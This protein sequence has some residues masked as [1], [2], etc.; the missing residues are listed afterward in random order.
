VKKNKIIFLIGFILSVPSI[1]IANSNLM[2]ANES[3]QGILKGQVL[4]NTSGDALEAA[5]VFVQGTNKGA[6]TDKDGYFIISNIPQGT[7]TIIFSFIG[8]TEKSLQNIEIVSNDIVN[9]GV[10]RLKEDPIAL[11]EIIVT[12]GSF[13]IMG[14]SPVS[15]QT[16]SNEDMKNVSFAEDITRA[17]S[18]LPGISSNDFSSKFTVRGGE[19]DEVLFTLDGMELYEPFHQRDY[20]GGLFSIVDIETI[21][22]V[23]LLTGG[24]PAEYGDRQSGV[25][26]MKTKNIPDGQRQ[27][28]IGVSILNARFYTDG[29]FAENRG[30]YQ[31]SARRGMLD[32]AL[33]LVDETENIPTFYDMMGKVEYKINSNHSLSVHALQASDQTKV[34][35]ISEEAHDIHDTKYNNSYAWITLK[36]FLTPEL[37]A[38][39]LLYSGFISHSRNGDTDKPTELSDKLFFQL[40]DKRSYNFLGFKQDWLWNVSDRITF[41]SGFDIKQLNADYDYSYQLRDVRVQSDGSLTHYADAVDVQT[42]P[43]GQQAALYMSSRFKIADKVFMETGLRYDY[44]S[45]TNDNLYSPRVGFVYAFSKKTFLR[46]AWGHYYQTQFINNLDV[47]HASKSFNPAELSEH[48]VVGF[49]HLFSNNISIRLDGYYKDI[50]RMSPTYQNLRDPWEVFPESRND[51]I[52]LDIHGAKARGIELFLKYDIGRKISWWFSY[53]LAEALENIAAI[54]YDGLLDPQTGWLPRINNQLHTLYCDV[55]YRPNAKW[56]YNLSWQYYKGWPMTTYNY[57]FQ[58]LDDV[59]LHFY[60]SHNKFRGEEYPAYH[61]MDLRINR[62]FQLKTGE[63]SVYLHLINL[64]NRENLKKFDV[65][66]T[67]DSDTV[68]PDGNGGYKYFQDDKYW[69]GFIPAIGISWVF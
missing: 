29:N 63:L 57:Q 26:N 50:S 35:D 7:Y 9:V 62:H 11:S 58:V 3:S 28:S 4:D 34:R 16:L 48:Y 59:G 61:R 56:H 37:Y 64:Y 23:E 32:Q 40:D 20:A 24:F 42:K 41:K 46:S 30:K 2:Q 5:N 1:T 36:S 52:K 22:S 53:S 31:F 19:D 8:Y 12:P 18:R 44:A 60:P 45:Y 49:E 69:L 51:V 6:A 17:V 65:D 39:T 66:V 27:T 10:V 54:E 13:A 55:N 47:N 33:K 68:V 38:R 43:T 14:N 67:D 25:F 21:E 15:R